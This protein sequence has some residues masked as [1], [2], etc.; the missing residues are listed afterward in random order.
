MHIFVLWRKVINGLQIQIRFNRKKNQNISFPIP[1]SNVS[2]GIQRMVHEAAIF[3]SETDLCQRCRSFIC[4]VTARM[5]KPWN[6]E[7]FY[8][9]LSGSNLLQ[10]L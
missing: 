10:I 6:L 9:K 5:I 2:R 4:P 8:K 7:H 1:S 3:R